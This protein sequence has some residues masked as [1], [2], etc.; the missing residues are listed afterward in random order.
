MQSIAIVILLLVGN[1]LRGQV[2]RYIVK[3]TD[4]EGTAYSLDNPEEFLS[5]R[6]INRRNK[7]SIEITTQDIPVNSTYVSGIM[8]TGADVFF[9][10]KWFNAVLLQCDSS[11]LTEIESLPF[12][13]SV[14]YVAPGP[15]LIPGM[16]DTNPE[17]KEFKRSRAPKRVKQEASEYQNN[18]LGIDA[19]HDS[20]ITGEGIII[21]VTDG[22]FLGV[23]NQ[24]PFSHLYDNNRIIH[25]YD[26]VGGQSNVYQYSNH[27]TKVFSL[28]GAYEQGQFIGSAFDSD[29]ML[30]VTEDDCSSCEHRIEEYNW[31]FAA[32]FADSAGVDIINASLGY[33]WFEDP[34]MSYTP[35]QMDGNTAIISRAADIAFSKGI[36]VV[37]AAGNE[38]LNSWKIVTAPGDAHNV[39]SVGNINSNGSLSATS[40]VG[41]TADQ[42]LKPELVALGTS[43]KVISSS[44]NIVS[45]SGTSFSAPQIA[46]LSA[47][48]MQSYPDLSAEDLRFLMMETASNSTNPNYKIGHGVPNFNSLENFINF[49][50]SEQSFVLYPNPVNDDNLLLRVNNPDEISQIN[51]RIFNT[52]GQQVFEEDINFSWQYNTHIINMYSLDAGIYIFNLNLGDK[53]EK[54]KILKI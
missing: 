9:T 11:L 50:D 34:S 32:E 7:Q 6:A 12:V 3:L 18:L 48:I 31:V 44:G 8:Q 10:S 26:Y 43:V 46:G 20:G 53:V 35:S 22:G 51:L 47:L 40:S 21:A 45:G 5:N 19:L 28:L 17:S 52:N 14:E 54:I 38:G 30:F 33:N 25:T 23:D 29:Y 13:S 16:A 39:I 15:K 49:S 24:Q 1:D 36:V 41:P 37:S 42:R 4:K 2:N 27:G